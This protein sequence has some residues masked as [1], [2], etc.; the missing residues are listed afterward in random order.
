MYYTNLLLLATT[1][2]AISFPTFGKVKDVLNRRETTSSSACPAVW[3]KVSAELT[4]MFLT[5][6]QC[7]DDARAAIR[8]NFHECGSWETKL[9]PTGGCDGSIILANELTRVENKGLAGIAGKVQ[10]LAQKYGT[11]LGG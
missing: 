11:G 2:S 4:S 8:L 6:E 3:S 7:N 5:G 10:N 9:G 1:A